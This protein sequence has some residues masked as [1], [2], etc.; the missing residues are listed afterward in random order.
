MKPFFVLC[1]VLTLTK[2]MGFTK[3]IAHT[4]YCVFYVNLFWLARRSVN[5]FGGKKW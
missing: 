1:H 3:I 2:Q 5:I 4:V